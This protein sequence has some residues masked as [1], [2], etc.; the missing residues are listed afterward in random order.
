[1]YPSLQLP[2]PSRSTGESLSPDSPSRNSFTSSPNSVFS[3]ITPTTPE[4]DLLEVEYHDGSHSGRGRDHLIDRDNN[5][6]SVNTQEYLGRIGE[7]EFVGRAW[8]NIAINNPHFTNSQ[9]SP[10]V[11]ERAV[12]ESRRLQREREDLSLLEE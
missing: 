6:Y 1:M 11:L 9:R 5:I 12:E 4:Y 3:S 8:E 10:S 7:G 2:S